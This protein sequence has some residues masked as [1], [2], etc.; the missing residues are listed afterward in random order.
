MN[1]NEISKNIK[2]Y[3]E[4][5]WSNPSKI[6]RNKD[7]VILGWH[8]GYYEDGIKNIND[9]MLNMNYYI[10]RLLDIKQNETLNILDCGS[11]IGFTSIQL[12]KK[13]SK[14]N[15]YGI[16]LTK[17]E[18]DT[19]ND[20]KNKYS[21][22]NIQFKQG[23]YMNSN[24]PDNFFD[25]IFA[26]ESV[27]YAPN[28]VE[29]LNEIYRILK[30]NGRIIIVDTFISKD[31]INS[32]TVN[33]DNYWFHRNYSKQQLLTYYVTINN[34]LKYLSLKK[35]KNIETTNLTKSGNVKKLHV[36]C[37]L[38]YRIFPSLLANLSKNRNKKSVFYKIIYPL[39]FLSLMGYKF[40]IIMYSKP[41]YYSII[42][43]KD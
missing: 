41:G 26:L 38:F 11:G 35:Y 5:I 14:C 12:A 40:L 15:F 29:Y 28:K 30:P 16:A 34:F 37:F 27:I 4:N 36:Y 2:N 19:A 6:M 32:L 20:L 13:Y 43:S 10:E 9:A 17:Q 31:I 7:N 25:K 21:V 24:Y 18:I 39:R 3:Y 22:E 23:T 33:I 42:A 8:Y 1:N